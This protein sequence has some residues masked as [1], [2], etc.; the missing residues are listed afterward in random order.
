[1]GLFSPQG[2]WSSCSLNEL[3][4]VPSI[5]VEGPGVVWVDVVKV[6][7]EVLT[8]CHCGNLA[9]CAQDLLKTTSYDTVALGHSFYIKIN[10]LF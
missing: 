6:M 5:R 2:L 10:L 1:M 3:G 4:R 9:V 8:E 7:H